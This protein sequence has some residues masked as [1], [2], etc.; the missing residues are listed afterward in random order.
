MDNIRVIKD[1][2]KNYNINVNHNNFKII[3]SNGI[4][5]LFYNSDFICYFEN[6]D[7]N[8]FD[9][10]ITSLKNYKEL[11]DR[12]ANHCIICI[13]NKNDQLIEYI[14]RNIQNMKLFQIVL[15]GYGKQYLHFGVKYNIEYL[16]APTNDYAMMIQTGL[17]YIKPQNMGNIVYINNTDTLIS[18]NII[19]QTVNQVTQTYR[20]AGPD[21]MKYIDMTIDNLVLNQIYIGDRN[22]NKLFF[23]NWFMVNKIFLNTINWKLFSDK[24]NIYDSIQ[25]YIQKYAIKILYVNNSTICFNYISHLSIP[26]PFKINKYEQNEL[27][28]LNEFIKINT[29]AP[30]YAMIIKHL[31][32]I[33]KLD[34]RKDQ[35]KETVF[36]FTSPKNEFEQKMSVDKL[37][38]IT[39]NSIVK[40]NIELDRI[41]HTVLQ[42]DNILTNH[43]N[44]LKDAIKLKLEKIMIIHDYVLNKKILHELKQERLFPQI[45]H[46]IFLVH[47]H[48]KFD[49][50]K[51]SNNDRFI[52]NIKDITYCVHHTIFNDYLNALEMYKN[53]YDSVFNFQKNKFI[54]IAKDE[55]NSHLLLETKKRN[56]DMEVLNK[57]RLYNLNQS[58][59]ITDS[60]KIKFDSKIFNENK[61]VQSLCIKESLNLNEILSITSF[62]NNGHEFHLYVYDDI[63]NIPKGCILKDANEIIQV[64][65]FTNENI[66]KYKLLYEKGNYW[67]DLDFICLQF[68]YFSEKYF[69]TYDTTFR[70]PHS[71]IIKCNRG[72]EIAKY[73]YN[74]CNNNPYT[75][76]NNQILEEGIKKYN[77]GGYV[78]PWYYF[79]PI[80]YDNLSKLLTPS[81]IHIDKSWYCIHL[82]EKFFTENNLDT[83]KI[84]YGSLYC[85]LINK[86]CK[87]HVSH[88]IFNLELEYGKYNR[89]CV[90][91]YWMPK[92]EKLVNSV[93]NSLNNIDTVYDI[94]KCYVHKEYAI[95]NNDRVDQF[96]HNDIYVYMFLRLLEYGIIDNLHIIFGIAPN[97]KYVYNNE[98]LFSNGNYYNFND[99]VHL[100]KLNDLHSLLSFANAKLYF[101]KGYGNYEHFYS[102]LTSISPHSIFIR[103]LA[104]ALPYTLNNRNEIIIDD[105]L[106]E[107]YANNMVYK[108]KVKDFNSY[109]STYYTNYDLLY[110]DTIDKIKHYK[111]VFTNTKLFLQFKKY[112]LMQYQEMERKYDLMFCASDSHPSKNWDILYDFLV[113]CNKNNKHLTVLI[114]TPDITDKSLKK[115]Q[116]FTTI[117]TTLKRGLTSTEMN[118]M[119]NQTKCLFV[120]FG[121][122]AN[123]RVISESLNCGCYN[124]VM[125]ILSDGKD[126]IK[127][128]PNLGSII[129]NSNTFYVDSYKSISCTITP[130]NCEK[131]YGLIKQNHNHKDISN[132]FNKLYNETTVTD[133]LYHYIKE[134]EKSKQKLVITLATD[135]YANSLNYLLISIK[136]T[137]PYQMVIVYYIDWSDNLLNDFKKYYPNFYFEEIKLGEYTKGD[138]IKLKVQVQKKAYFTYRLPFI[139]IDADSIVL[140]SLE[141]LFDK[142]DKYNLI[143]YYRP[144]E[145]YYMKFAVGVI[146][147]GRSNNNEIQELN[148]KIINS[149]YDNSLITE[150]YNNWFYDQTS[151]YDTYLLYEKVIQLYKL[152]EHEHSINDTPD[153]IIYSRRPN[154]KIQIS[155]ILIHNGLNIPNIDFSGI[156]LKYK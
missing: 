134:T 154:N 151:L 140:K 128:N 26:L 82:H 32:D 80:N 46:M 83:N 7:Q 59:F 96:I 129:Y 145:N 33:N 49:I 36:N 58:G 22:K 10:V 72:S 146:G 97:D 71:G 8:T 1:Y 24:T 70:L 143:C 116:Q 4:N 51:L 35:V 34:I 105:T 28:T 56:Y 77:L 30:Y 120:T 50:I 55:F 123:P 100:W 43:I 12:R 121:R 62:I 113:Y 94:K 142:I 148:E 108:E 85:Q 63:T 37:Y 29:D 81:N 102:M 92:D 14:I 115:F 86:N 111:K 114:V 101:Y 144:E 5:K 147:F 79:C 95:A 45:W 64:D 21:N 19:R 133:E 31:D 103:Y 41:N 2:I 150:G 109:F 118:E 132:A 87:E 90:L 136:Y 27:Q 54:Y 75:K 78:K 84:Y 73:C 74:M 93:E 149:Y 131:I 119:Y 135:T 44:A 65:S 117:N 67:V 17:T 99:N 127:N 68:L 156:E 88:E 122:D 11:S 126:L 66:F 20:I 112:S 137:N 125:D 124:I 3:S 61:I 138:I 155:D 110:I 15:I 76:L 141:P 139:W 153:T 13:T 40:V 107:T 53:I 98:P 9:K 23:P 25:T 69:F 57:R 60:S 104:T 48:T 39:E 16:S 152:G 106:V 47:T 91:F 130:D 52:Y 18:Y 38:I 89:S 6:L 42:S